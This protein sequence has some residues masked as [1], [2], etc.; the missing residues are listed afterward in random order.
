M[1]LAPTTTGLPSVELSSI[2]HQRDCRSATGP[3]PK[4]QFD[5]QAPHR[6]HC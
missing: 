6:F 3:Y 5:L 4:R 1:F 2:T